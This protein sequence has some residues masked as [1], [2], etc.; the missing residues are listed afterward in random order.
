M[1]VN[2]AMRANL[3]GVSTQRSILRPSESPPDFVADATR[4]GPLPASRNH[5]WALRLGK[6][7]GKGDHMANLAGVVQQLKKERDQVARTVERLD[8][9]IAAL[10][11]NGPLKIL[12]ALRERGRVSFAG[13]IVAQKINVVC[14]RVN[15]TSASQVL[16]LL[17]P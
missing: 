15:G 16:P 4:C 8:A 7:P 6:I 10:N 14:V 1:A 17:G 9:A 13:V 12:D 3:T 2:R 11:A 5:Q